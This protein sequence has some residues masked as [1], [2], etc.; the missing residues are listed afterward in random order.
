MSAPMLP[1]FVVILAAL[2]ACASNAKRSISLYEA[3]KYEA[4]AKA[5]D[6]GLADHPD[7]AALWGMRVRSA[8][9]LGKPEDIARA[10]GDYV[11]KRGGD[12]HE[13]LRDLSNATLEQAIASPSTILKLRAIA[14]IEELELGDLAEDVGQAM[15]DEDERVQA[16]AAVAV[17]HGF[18]QAAHVAADMLHADNAEARRIALD[19]VAK[20]IG[21]IAL[22]DIEKGA[23]DRDPRVRAVA[24]RWLGHY[25]D[26]DAVTVCTKR[27]HDPD[28]SVRA[29]AATALAQI[30]LGDI[31]AVAKRALAD[32]AL[33]VRLAGVGVLETSN[34]QADYDKLVALAGDPNALVALEAALAVK[35]LHPD[36]AATAIQRA[37]ASSEWTVRA[38]G[39]NSLTRALDK[40][41]AI[42]AAKTATAD[43]ELAVR[44]A[45][46][47]VLAHAG[48][49]A[50]ATAVYSAALTDADAAA[51]LGA[52]GDPRGV[53]ALD[54]LASDPKRTPEQRAAAISAHRTARRVTP[55]LVAALADA[56]GL[57]R[58]EA[59]A[60]LAALAK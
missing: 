29:A 27:L 25:K 50:D 47:R 45:A 58:V 52:L 44:L 31:A 35:K 38:G 59:A 57:V 42:T 5:A 28:E 46:A 19:G 54:A 34:A 48:D 32:K 11:A 21:R 8:V 49:V 22:P 56:S 17:I 40:A 55:T 41:A 53:A 33:V 10:Y 7:D 14:T 24:V 13:L 39:V 26:V 16:A 60:T 12:D 18:A 43:A 23:T 1:R 15:S 20:K 37:L 4:A 51:E 9:A 2:T 6:E 30:G 36:L 3:G